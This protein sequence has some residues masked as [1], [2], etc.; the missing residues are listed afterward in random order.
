M[1]FKTKYGHFE[2][3]VMPMRLRN[4]PATIQALMN[5]IFCNCIDDFRVI[6]LDDILIFNNSRQEQLSHLQTVLERLKKNELYVGKDKYQLMTT[7]TEFLG[8]SIGT[9][10]VHIGTERKKLIKEWPKPAKRH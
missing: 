4:A 9:K 10:G 7:E 2:Y 1:V 5:S 3:L 8:L 6:Y